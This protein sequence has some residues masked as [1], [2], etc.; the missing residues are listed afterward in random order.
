MAL[1]GADQG[2]LG[3]RLAAIDVEREGDA[4]TERLRLKKLKSPALVA[5]GEH[6]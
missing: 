1:I 2:Q 5:V 3:L 6:R 4:V